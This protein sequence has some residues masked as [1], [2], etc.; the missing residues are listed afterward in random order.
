MDVLVD[1]TIWSLALRR[2]ARNLNS[3]EQSLVSECAELATNGRAG[4]IGLVRQ[5]VLSGIKTNAQFEALRESLRAFIDESVDS[6]D[7]EAAAQAYNICQSKGLAASAVDMLICAVAQRR[8]MSIF[9]TDP[10]F[11]RY[12]RVLPLK[13]HSAP[14]GRTTHDEGS[15][16]NL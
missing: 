4:I 2:K 12:A 10:D 3:R 14:G 8:G 9:T 5:E 7:Y 6:N 13:L 16:L 11:E 1:A 15:A